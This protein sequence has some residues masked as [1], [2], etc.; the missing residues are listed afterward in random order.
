MTKNGKRVTAFVPLDGA[1]N[2]IDN[3]EQVVVQ[4]M[5]RGGRTVGDIPGCRFMVIKISNIGIY[6]IFYGKKEKRGH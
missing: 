3:N 4:S 1:I 6:A 2:F 5:G